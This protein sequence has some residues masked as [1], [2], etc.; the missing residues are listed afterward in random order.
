MWSHHLLPLRQR[1]WIRLNRN[2]GS[3]LPP[4]WACNRLILNELNLSAPRKPKSGW[5]LLKQIQETLL[6]NS[7]TSPETADCRHCHEYLRWSF[8]KL[9]SRQCD[10]IFCLTKR[11]HSHKSAGEFG[12]SVMRTYI[13]PHFSSDIV[14]RPVE[15]FQSTRDNWSADED[16]WPLDGRGDETSRR[17][18][19]PAEASIANRLSWVRDCSSIDHHNH[20]HDLFRIEP[21]SLEY[22]VV[23]VRIRFQGWRCGDLNER[24]WIELSYWDDPILNI[25]GTK[26]SQLSPSFVRRR[27]NCSLNMEVSPEVNCSWEWKQRSPTSCWTIDKHL[28]KSGI[29]IVLAKGFAK[30][31]FGASAYSFILYVQFGDL[32]E[33]GN[34][35]SAD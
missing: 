30:D 25:C 27:I 18:V 17:S 23:L 13:A 7:L 33:Y 35:E 16:S 32:Y 1:K 11:V 3:P 4:K 29:K 21:S 19:F 6:V 28:R 2:N 10:Q 9:T 34:N 31:L 8:R 14:V 5:N 20:K 22:K 24:V 12:V 15:F 26:S